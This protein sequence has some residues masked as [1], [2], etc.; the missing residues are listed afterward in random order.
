MC[1]TGDQESLLTNQQTRGIFAQLLQ[2][3][4][5]LKQQFLEIHR[6]LALVKNTMHKILIDVTI[7]ISNDHPQEKTERELL[8]T[9]LSS[10]ETTLVTTMVS[11]VEKQVQDYLTESLE[12]AVTNGLKKHT[13]V[14][15]KSPITSNFN[16]N[17]HSV[18][19]GSCIP[20][21]QAVP[22]R[23]N[24]VVS[25]TEHEGNDMF[26]DTTKNI[27]NHS[28]AM[29]NLTQLKTCTAPETDVQSVPLF[30]NNGPVVL[31]SALFGDTS[32]GSVSTPCDIDLTQQSPSVCS[33]MFSQHLERSVSGSNNK[34]RLSIKNMD[35]AQSNTCTSVE[36]DLTCGKFFVLKK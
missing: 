8:C 34:K 21:E 24:A 29:L 28:S 10:L 17:I 15:T 22:N 23:S 16:Q 20:H 2:G 25:N 1:F 27:T 30:S 7:I 35:P 31:N 11:T 6:Q 9:R 32:Q 4:A 12:T 3:Q 36:K 18:S 19:L 14:S 5:E 13:C 33:Q 26:E